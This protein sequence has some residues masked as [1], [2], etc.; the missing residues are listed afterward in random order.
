MVVDFRIPFGFDVLICCWGCDG[1]AHQKDIGLWVRERTQAVLRRELIREISTL[2]TLSIH[3]LLVLLCLYWK[4]VKNRLVTKDSIL[5]HSPKP[6]DLPSTI[7]F[8]V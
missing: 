3:N 4:C 7:T 8:A 1:V 6:T 5:P 2:D